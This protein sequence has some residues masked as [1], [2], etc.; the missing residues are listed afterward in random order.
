MPLQLAPGLHR[1]DFDP[2]VHGFAFPNAFVDTLVTLPGGATISTAGRCGGM[3]ALALDHFHAGLPA[4]RWGSAL[5]AP[6]RVPPDGH[7]LSEA[8]RDRQLDSFRVGSALKF[9]TWSLQGDGPTWVLPGITR[10]T[11]QDELPRL[12][13]LLRAGVP[14]VLGLVVARDL[15]SV[16]QNHQVVAYG[17]EYDIVAGRTTILLHDPNSP[18]REVTLVGHDDRPGWVASNGRVW[19]GFFVHDYVRH[20]PPALTRDPAHPDR[21]IRLGDHVVL[22]HAW[23]GRVLHGGED[24]YRHPGTSGQHRVTADDAVD[25][26]HWQLQPRHD[27]RERTDTTEPVTSGDVLRL[28]LHGTDRHLHS[29]RGIPSP[30]SHQQEVT[31]FADRDRNDDWRVVVDGDGPWLAGSRIRL[32][33]VRSGANLQ[34]HP[35]PGDDE[36]EVTASALPDDDG[37]WTVLEVG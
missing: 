24:R 16:A 11:E 7:W 4:P 19:R 34:T 3:A 13:A 14:V 31:T 1:V 32:E 8:I 26:T 10:R 15:R 33:H 20:E 29:H 21:P 25:G 17:Y 9:L 35:A 2:L 6:S 27:R 22:V 36:Q 12:A 18:G 30:T 28:R 23:T 5:W 37:W